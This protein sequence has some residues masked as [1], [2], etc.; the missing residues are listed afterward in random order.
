MGVGQCQSARISDHLG[1]PSPQELMVLP[2]SGAVRIRILSGCVR[3]EVKCGVDQHA[4]PVYCRR[5]TTNFLGESDS[6]S[7][8]TKDAPNVGEVRWG[9]TGEP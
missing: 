7:A 5:E 4:S 3:P 1:V 9:V 2:K 6:S 8:A